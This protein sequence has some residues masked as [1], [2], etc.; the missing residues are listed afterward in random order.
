[1]AC[2]LQLK[3]ETER[4][5]APVTHP[6]HTIPTFTQTPKGAFHDPPE[7]AFWNHGK[8]ALSIWHGAAKHVQADVMTF[9]VPRRGTGAMACHIR[10]SEALQLTLGSGQA[11][12]GVALTGDPRNVAATV[13]IVAVGPREQDLAPSVD[14]L[15]FIGIAALFFAHSVHLL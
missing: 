10:E 1:M 7:C 5:N 6:V 14:A 13:I 15:H 8:D 2:G 3:R 11:Q 12:S 4:N 9:W